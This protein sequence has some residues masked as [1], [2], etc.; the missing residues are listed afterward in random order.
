MRTEGAHTGYR[1]QKAARDFTQDD[2][3]EARGDNPHHV[4]GIG[5]LGGVRCYIDLDWETAK[6]RFADE[7]YPD[8]EKAD[9]LEYTAIAFG[10]VDTFEVYDIEE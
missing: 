4:I 7:F 3:D 10:F 6:R 5:S 2:L 9:P 8:D 1:I